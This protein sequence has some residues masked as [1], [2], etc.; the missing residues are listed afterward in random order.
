[1]QKDVPMKLR[2]NLG[3]GFEPLT[4]KEQDILKSRIKNGR[5]RRQNCLQRRNSIFW[6]FG[7]LEKTERILDRYLYERKWKEVD[8]DGYGNSLFGEYGRLYEYEHNGNYSYL[9][10]RRRTNFRTWEEERFLCVA[11]G[12]WEELKNYWESF[13][14]ECDEWNSHNNTV[15]GGF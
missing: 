4:Q 5:E 3:T 10:T 2:R 7:K 14:A 9:I 6:N 11:E 12:S 1:M 8:C 15:A 13:V